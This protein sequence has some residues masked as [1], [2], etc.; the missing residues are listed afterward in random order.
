M[1]GSVLIQVFDIKGVCDTASFADNSRHVR[2]RW[3]Y[4]RGPPGLL[5]DLACLAWDCQ[6][7]YEKF[8]V[9]IVL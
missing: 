7:S 9:G 6:S 2:R 5:F 1:K 4:C 8:A 3:V